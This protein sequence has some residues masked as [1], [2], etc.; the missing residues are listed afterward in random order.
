MCPNSK[1]QPSHRE[2]EVLEEGQEQAPTGENAIELQFLVDVL[3]LHGIDSWPIDLLRRHCVV[4]LRS[5]QAVKT[6]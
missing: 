3:L 2:R 4:R 5:S 1:N 6:S